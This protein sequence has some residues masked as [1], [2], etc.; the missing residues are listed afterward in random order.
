[1]N[2]LYRLYRISKMHNPTVLT[3][4]HRLHTDLMIEGRVSQFRRTYNATGGV[5]L[6]LLYTVVCAL[7]NKMAKNIRKIYQASGI[8][9]H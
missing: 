4:F 5:E 8:P 3:N 9:I 7:D 1:M 6:Y 2:V